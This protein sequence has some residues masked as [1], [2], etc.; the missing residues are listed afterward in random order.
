MT[1]HATMLALLLATTVQ[2][3]PAT[4]TGPCEA[5]RPPEGAWRVER[6]Y[7][8]AATASAAEEE[9]Q[10][11][12]RRQLVD[13]V[14]A[15]LTPQE[16]AEVEAHVDTSWQPV[17]VREAAGGFEACAVAIVR[18]RDVSERLRRLSGDLDAQLKERAASLAAG[19]GAKGLVRAD[20]PLWDDGTPAD[21]LGREMHLRWLGAVGLPVAGPTDTAWTAQVRGQLGRGG[22][23]T[24]RLQLF[25]QR[26][27]K[28]GW[29]PLEPVSFNPMAVGLQSCAP[30]AEGALSDARLG[31][32]AGS[33]P[34]SGGLEL[35]LESPPRH[36]LLCDGERFS[37]V[38]E[39]SADAWVRVYSVAEDGRVLLGWA[40]DKPVR[41]FAP[42]DPAV[43]V[44]L[45]GNQRDRMI[46][47]AIPAN[48]GP[49]AFAGLPTE[50]TC[51]GTG[52]DARHLPP[53]AAVAS[54]A[55]SVAAPGAAGC[56]SDPA[57]RAEGDAMRAAIAALPRCAA[58]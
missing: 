54:L 25:W 29:L 15:P 1:R 48:L 23:D 36:D 24:C 28:P 19:L 30:P 18:Q 5:P 38:A 9:A 3:A 26:R 45:P 6:G 14:A 21:A 22:G 12:A 33:R 58:R 37:V 32:D 13:A 47:V 43:G 10:A 55:H 46:A 2:A 50:P 57:K 16:R 11:K 44:R 41:R 27:G 56:P 31:L 53:E 7:A 39:A 20:I 34:G 8:R 49:G 40:S 4:W 52:F 17:R 51:F 35:R 42:A